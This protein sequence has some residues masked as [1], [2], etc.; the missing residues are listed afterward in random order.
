MLDLSVFDSSA[1]ICALIFFRVTGF[2]AVCPLITEY[3]VPV[4]VIIMFSF[5]YSLILSGNEAFIKLYV[6]DSAPTFDL[7]LVIGNSFVGVVFGLVVLLA[8]QMVKMAGKMTA[9]AMQMGF[10]QMVDPANG[11]SS[12]AV[13]T[14]M[15]IVFSL[16]FVSSGGLMM[17]FDVLEASFVKYPLTSPFFIG[18]QLFNL[19]TSFSYTFLYGT[20]IAIPFTAAGLLINTAL[21]VIS[22]SAPSMN[23]FTI[24]F[25]TCIFLGIIGMYLLGEQI[26]LDM[27]HYLF[28]LKH[29]HLEAL[30]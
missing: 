27:L 2:F 9:F 25:P 3:K 16:V 15:Y 8:F 23:L 21:A 5:G 24:G 4:K 29:F 17:F 1:M 12:D 10:L 11:K 19:V 30:N 20:L 14:F 26:Y 18:D 28:K 7:L 6:G 13:S 22:K